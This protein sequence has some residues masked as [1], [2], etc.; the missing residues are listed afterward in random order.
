MELVGLFSHT[1]PSVQSLSG[2]G[3]RPTYVCSLN[4]LE[5]PVH[6]QGRS[7]AIA[8]LIGRP[9]LDVTRRTRPLE[10]CRRIHTLQPKRIASANHVLCIVSGLADLTILC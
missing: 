8:S 2:S 6:L 5:A 3:L 4:R 9:L 10:V 7:H 1:T